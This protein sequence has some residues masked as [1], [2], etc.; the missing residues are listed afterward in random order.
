MSPTGL[1]S[2][3]PGGV[4]GGACRR[5]PHRQAVAVADHRHQAAGTALIRRST[6][7]S[8][9]S[10]SIDELW[11]DLPF[12]AH[13]HHTGQALILIPSAAQRPVWAPRVRILR[14]FLGFRIDRDFVDLSRLVISRTDRAL[15]RSFWA[16]CPFRSRPPGPG[17]RDVSGCPAPAT[18]AEQ[19]HAQQGRM[20][21]GPCQAPMGVVGRS[22]GEG[23][24]AFQAVTDRHPGE[25]GVTAATGDTHR[26][27][28]RRGRVWPGP[29]E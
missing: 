7:S 26:S 18:I 4:H 16:M 24:M 10:R 17:L 29:K 15:R 21:T 6:N 9:M 11:K 27:S 2:V 19:R 28:P 20:H 8:T 12:F 25:G 22:V 1:L 13:A 23:C 14:N 5:L 3:V